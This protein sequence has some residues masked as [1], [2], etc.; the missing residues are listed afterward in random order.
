MR[1]LGR[2]VVAVVV[3]TLVFGL[4][5]PLLFTGFAQLASRVAQMEA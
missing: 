4:A 3:L 2:S 1:T 5:Y